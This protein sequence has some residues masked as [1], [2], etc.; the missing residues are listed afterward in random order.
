M[1]NSNAKS[2]LWHRF[3]GIDRRVLFVLVFLAVFIPLL[4]PIGMPVQTSPPVE[5]IFNAIEDMDPAKD[6]IMISVDY[7]PSVQPEIFPMHVALLS[8]CFTRGIPVV[9]ICLQPAG[10]A[11]GQ[12]A[13]RDA[14]ERFPDVVRGEDYCYLGFKP[15]PVAVMLS[16]GEGIG[17]AF[18][19]DYSGTPIE[20]IPLMQRVNTYDEI[21]LVI[22]LGLLLPPLNPPWFLSLLPPR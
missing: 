15:G 18:P 20:E 21:T 19:A 12:L 3:I 6:I 8:H 16:I 22:S 2:G 5:N 17:G 11:L 7:D 13:I 9:Q 10:V 14:R 4:K 1:S